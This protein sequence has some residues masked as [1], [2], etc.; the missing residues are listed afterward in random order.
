MEDDEYDEPSV[1][2][3]NP[4]VRE[5]AQGSVRSNRSLK[6]TSK[7][8]PREEPASKAGGDQVA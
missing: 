4:K 7:L 5:S 2:E 8:E 3:L 6:P 1:A